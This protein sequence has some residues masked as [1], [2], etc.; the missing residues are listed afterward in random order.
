MSD[1][2]NIEWAEVAEN[3]LKGII[4]YIAFSANP[5][6]RTYR[7]KIVIDNSSVKLR[8]GMIVRVKFIR[9]ELK[10]VVSAPL[11]AVMD[12][13]GEK[14]VFVAENGL[15]KKVNVNIGSSIGQRIVV[16][17]GLVANQSLIIEGQQLLLDGARIKV[18][19]K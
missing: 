18:G 15:A 12:R 11:F 19:E 8:P 6:T 1:N 10:Q 7:T 2:Y 9:Q 5:S 13:D 3:D 4:E 17:Q 14:I 16:E